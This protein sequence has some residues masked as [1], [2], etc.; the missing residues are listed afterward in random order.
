MRLGILHDGHVL[1]LHHVFPQGAGNEAFPTGALLP[2]HATAMGK[3]L[4]AA[5]PEA[6]AE[7]AS[8]ELRPFTA[9][10]ITDPDTLA[11]SLEQVRG[12]GWAAS[13]EEFVEGTSAVAAPITS[14]GGDAV[15]ALSI[16]GPTDR[17]CRSREPREALAV[18]L[19][20]YAWAVSRDLG[21]EPWEFALREQVRASAA[22]R[23]QADLVRQE[24]RARVLREEVEVR[25]P[26]LENPWRS[27]HGPYAGATEEMERTL[28][29]ERSELAEMERQLCQIR[30]RL[31][32][33]ERATRAQ[34]TLRVHSD[35]PIVATTAPEKTA[36]APVPAAVSGAAA[37]SD[38][39][40]ARPPSPL[41]APAAKAEFI[42]GAPAI[43]IFVEEFAA[44]LL[45][46]S[47]TALHEQFGAE[48]GLCLQPRVE[49][50][51]GRSAPPPP[52][53]DDVLSA[54]GG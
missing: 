10:T 42:L 33:A 2:L 52:H 29:R 15:G 19:C 7:V 18:S 53:E 17:L 12:R 39:I 23:L 25:P 37:A 36:V 20:D 11:K 1:V 28:S 22:L 35:P 41:G 48:L 44:R 50:P 46:R 40:G 14:H 31:R 38:G 26:V 8:S 4:L 45:E 54:V 5:C 9:A 34:Q 24:R 43:R 47:Q 13:I 49:N 27:R 32:G 6:E 21:A 51:P 3:A 16:S 30:Q